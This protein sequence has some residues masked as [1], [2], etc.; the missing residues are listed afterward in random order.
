ML[1]GCSIVILLGSLGSETL[2]YY[3]LCSSRT[4][5]TG[6]V[7][8]A[9]ASLQRVL[10]VKRSRPRL[11]SPPAYSRA[12]EVARHCEERLYRQRHSRPMYVSNAARSDEGR[13]H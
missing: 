10:C 9:A 6:G 2:L 11:S 4:I 5:V 12:P 3:R 1:H 8:G 13:E 7:G